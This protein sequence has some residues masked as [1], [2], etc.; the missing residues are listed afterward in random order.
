[1]VSRTQTRYAYGIEDIPE[2][3]S[4]WAEQY[5]LTSHRKRFVA[6][7]VYCYRTSGQVHFDTHNMIEM[8]NKARWEKPTNPADIIAKAANSRFFEVS[9]T[10][11]GLKKWQ[12]TKTGFKYLDTLRISEG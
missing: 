4:E 5:A 6:I 11:N 9:S 12:L 1:M 7:A 8:Y 3:F 2:T 10:E